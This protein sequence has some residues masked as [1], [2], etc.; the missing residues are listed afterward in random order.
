[1]PVSAAKAQ[2]LRKVW[3]DPEDGFGSQAATLKQAVSEILA[4]GLQK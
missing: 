2:I 4:S 1:M 3:Y